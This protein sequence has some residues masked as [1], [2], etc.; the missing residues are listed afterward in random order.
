MWKI[1]H[2]YSHVLHLVVHQLQSQGSESPFPGHLPEPETNT[3]TTKQ[4]TFSEFFT[5]RMADNIITS[6]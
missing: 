1:N 6:L 3:N 2:H 5:L 4:A